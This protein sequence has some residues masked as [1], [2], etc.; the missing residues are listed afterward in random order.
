MFAIFIN[1]C[2]YN[3]IQET[4]KTGPASVKG[5]IFRPENAKPFSNLRIQFKAYDKCDFGKTGLDRFEDSTDVN[6]FFS[7]DFERESDYSYA[8]ITQENGCYDS[9]KTKVV[10]CYSDNFS[11]ERQIVLKAI[12]AIIHFTADTAS[13]G[14]TIQFF[15]GYEAKDTLGKEKDFSTLLVSEETVTNSFKTEYISVSDTTF[16]FVW[17]NVTK[18]PELWQNRLLKYTSGCRN[19][20]IIIK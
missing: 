7:F 4:Q 11:F 8:L 5:Y 3:N 19:D 14:D 9:S 10:D 16:Y 20:T 2:K 12:K 18:A 1:G 17:K 15:T 6:G 13:V